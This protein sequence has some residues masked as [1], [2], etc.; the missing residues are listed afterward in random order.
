MNLQFVTYSVRTREQSCFKHVITLYRT[1]IPCHER[2]FKSES[3]ECSLWET[4][5]PFQCA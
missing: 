1:G 4:T 5:R 2:S 3:Y